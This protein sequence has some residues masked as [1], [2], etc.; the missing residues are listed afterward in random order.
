MPREKRNWRREVAVLAVVRKETRSVV[1]GEKDASGTGIGASPSSLR[2][3]KLISLPINANTIR[4]Q[5]TPPYCRTNE[6]SFG[7]YRG[8]LPNSSRGFCHLS[9]ARLSQGSAAGIGDRRTRRMRSYDLLVGMRIG[10]ERWGVEAARSPGAGVADK[11]LAHLRSLREQRAG[12]SGLH[13][14]A[15]VP[16]TRPAAGRACGGSG[17]VPFVTGSQPDL[18][19]FLRTLA[20]WGVSGP[21]M[22]K[23]CLHLSLPSFVDGRWS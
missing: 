9:Q 11:A 14:H 12:C 22:E 7:H 20:V 17:P 4:R 6:R 10:Q 2:R 21:R 5:P 18:P 16:S 15:P 19:P 1:L 8:R 23:R 13:H 3:N